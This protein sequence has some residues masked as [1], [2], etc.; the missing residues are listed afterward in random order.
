[1]EKVRPWCGQPSDRG[2]LK[3]RTEQRAFCPSVSVPRPTVQFRVRVTIAPRWK[4]FTLVSVAAV[5]CVYT[6]ALHAAIIDAWTKSRFWLGL[7]KRSAKHFT[8][9][10][11]M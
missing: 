4:S 6:L 7:H 10:N 5:V 1:M 8:V 3:N 11:Y 2:R 9:V